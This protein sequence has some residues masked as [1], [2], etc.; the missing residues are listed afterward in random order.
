M[1]LAKSDTKQQLQ[2]P[3]AF[4]RRYNGVL[5]MLFSCKLHH[6]STRSLS[7]DSKPMRSTLGM[8]PLST[9]HTHPT[10]R[11]A[12]QHFGMLEHKSNVVMPPRMSVC[13]SALARLHTWYSK[14]AIPSPTSPP[15]TH[16]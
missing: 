11:S 15:P 10:E 3:A 1:S 7:I 8:L 5:L 6:F 16:L 14:P 2:A 13:I 9:L 4:F 12:S